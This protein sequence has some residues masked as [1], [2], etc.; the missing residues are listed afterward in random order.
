MSLLL[1][2]RLAKVSIEPGTYG[3]KNNLLPRNPVKLMPACEVSI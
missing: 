1:D 3:C 2:L